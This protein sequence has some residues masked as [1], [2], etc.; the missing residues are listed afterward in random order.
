M[1]GSFFYRRLHDTG[2]QIFPS[3]MHMRV[4]MNFEK[5]DESRC[6]S[7]R[8]IICMAMHITDFS[9]LS[10]FSRCL[11]MSFCIFNYTTY[12]YMFS[13]L[14]NKNGLLVPSTTTDQELQH[15]RNSLPDKIK[16][17]RVEEKLSALGN[18][19]ACNDHVALVHPDVDQDTEEIIEDVLG[20]EVFRHSVAKN[21]LVGSYCS[22]SNQG[23]L[24]SS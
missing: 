24:V 19:I 4:G 7:T 14:G 21:V 9:A 13:F 16:I 12:L 2:V 1:L 5:T 15:L 6:C 8:L 17:Q 11:M 18:C 20:V 3:S 22:L 23:A 10:G